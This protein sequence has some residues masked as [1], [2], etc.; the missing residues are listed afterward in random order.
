MYSL[1]LSLVMARMPGIIQF[2]FIQVG[3]CL[4]GSGELVKTPDEKVPQ[5]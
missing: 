4:E 2:L 5:D 1:G 3:M